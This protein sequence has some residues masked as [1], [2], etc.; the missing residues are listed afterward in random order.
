MLA[1]PAAFVDIALTAR[2]VLEAHSGGS[3]SSARSSVLVLGRFAFRVALAVSPRAFQSRHAFAHR[4]AQMLWHP[5][6]GVAASPTSILRVGEDHGSG[7][8]S[9][10]RGDRDP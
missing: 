8:L 5:V 10:V 3:E 7:V 9:V 6:G 4:F 2:R 1:R